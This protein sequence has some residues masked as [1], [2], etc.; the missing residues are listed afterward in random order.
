MTSSQD[1]LVRLSEDLEQ[2]PLL[3]INKQLQAEQDELSAIRCDAHTITCSDLSE[4]C[5]MMWIN[6]TRKILLEF[7]RN[8]YARFQV[9]RS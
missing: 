9:N 6:E 7:S 2:R 1:S 3:I 5:D 4:C 8:C